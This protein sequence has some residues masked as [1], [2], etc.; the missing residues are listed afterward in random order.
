MEPYENSVLLDKVRGCLYGGAIG[1]AMGAPVEWYTP[2]RMR[3]LYGK[4]TDFVP[5]VEDNDLRRHRTEGRFTDDS[6]M[7]QALS[8]AYIDEGGHLDAHSFARRI[9]PVILEPRWVSIL[10]RE[11]PIVELLF[12]PEKW[13]YIRNGLANAD[14]RLGGVGN[15]VN[16]G[17]AMYAAPI[18]IV[19]AG[20]PVSA[21]HE[22]VDVL[23]AHQ[24]S[25]GLEAA[26]VMATAVAEAFRPGA[27]VDSIID[28]VLSL[29]KDGTRKA[30][31]AV[32]ECA[33]AY[34]DWAEAIGPLRDAMRPWDG[35]PDVLGD[36]GKGNNDNTP[37]REH[38]IEEVPIA[39]A[40]LVVAKGDFAGSICGG[41][42][43]GRD[44]DTI[45]G[46]AGAIAGAL[47]GASAMRQDWIE[48]VRRANDIDLDPMAG[49]LTA[50]I[51]KLQ[52][53]QLATAQ[54][55][56]ADFARL[57]AAH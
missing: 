56:E 28:V 39:L 14:P 21:Y 31:E 36:R 44:N 23:S 40:F 29:A 6:H 11:M 13:L 18:G 48:T 1:D 32:V 26:A 19:N 50:L 20:D 22:A 34:D 41:T 55:R 12:Y 30:I 15:M 9:I 35:A 33:R 57:L 43:Y 4:I 53:E 2:A 5:T 10:D 37:S 3:E 45:A 54:A 25:Y 51:C 52:Q 8:Q 7:V 46:M 38:S 47:Q 27:S 24:Y 16:C 42:N 49:E 17:A